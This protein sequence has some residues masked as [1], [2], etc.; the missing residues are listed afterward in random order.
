MPKVDPERQVELLQQ[1]W[2]PLKEPRNIF[3]AIIG[4]LPFLILSGLISYFIIQH[5]SPL[6]LEEL[7]ISEDGV[8]IQVNLLYLVALFL[9]LMIH[10]LLHLVFV[11]NFMKSDCTYIGLTWFGGYVFTEEIISKRRYIW[12]SLAPFI[13]ISIVLPLFLGVIPA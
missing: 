7:G 8:I 13:L 4:S 9:M 6:S 2:I 11:P 5:F 3:T 1:N 10:E 12:I